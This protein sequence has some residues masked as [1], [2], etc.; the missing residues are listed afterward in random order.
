MI[1]D[2]CHTRPNFLHSLPIVSLQAALEHM[3][4]IIDDP[5]QLMSGEKRG[6]AQEEGALEDAPEELIEVTGPRA[7]V[8]KS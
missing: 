7:E 2:T 3:E 6:E 5:H 1:L 4:S 8:K